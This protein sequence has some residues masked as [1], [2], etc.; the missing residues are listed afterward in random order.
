MPNSGTDSQ[1]IAVISCFQEKAS[2]HCYE[3]DVHP[4]KIQSC[5]AF[6]V[7]PQFEFDIKMVCYIIEIKYLRNNRAA[8]QLGA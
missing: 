6:D 7:V 3:Q 5:A 2:L 4:I 8:Q 1:M